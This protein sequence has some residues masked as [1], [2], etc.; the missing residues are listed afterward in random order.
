MLA[1]LLG[2]H[3]PT[4]LI[5]KILQ[6]LLVLAL[7]AVALADRPPYS[8]PAPSYQ[9]PSYADVPPKYEY[10]YAVKDDYSG[11]DFNAGESRDGAATSGEYRV[12]LPDGRT[13][14][15]GRSFGRRGRMT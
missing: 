13:Q 6:L 11:V 2:E 9:Q 10:A 7:S 15:S 12:L 14:V 5:L 4:F 3:L 8:P 1:T